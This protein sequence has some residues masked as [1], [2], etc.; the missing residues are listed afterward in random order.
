M[1]N[2][3]KLKTMV[4]RSIDQKIRLWNFDARH[5]K[6]ETGAVVT[7]DSVVLK[8]EKVFVTCG[9][10]KGCV[11]RETNVVSGMRV[12]IVRN[13][14]RKPNHPLSHNLQKHE[15]EVCRAREMPEAEVSLR[16]SIDRRVNN[17][18]KVLAPNRLVSIGILPNVNSIQPNRDVSS[19][20]S[21]HGWRTTK[22]KAE[23]GWWQKC[24]CYCGK[25]TTVELC[26]PGHWA[27]KILQRFLGRAQKCW[28]Q[29]DEYDSQELRCVKQTSE[30]A[31][32]HRWIKYKSNFLISA[33]P[34]LWNAMR[35][36]RRVGIWQ[37]IW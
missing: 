35:P 9:K 36:L 21:A 33:V 19:A 13:R 15:V 32:V 26:T 24:S 14:H 4:K 12:T 2:C 37:Q 27:A 31:K 11:R 30:K 29:C 17:S 10:K 34:T 1:P 28:K 5:E 7:R 16:S 3:Q 6:I 8:E 25:C 23:K 18:W 20:Q 22:Q